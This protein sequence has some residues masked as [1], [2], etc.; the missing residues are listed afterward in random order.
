MSSRALPF[1]VPGPLP[2]PDFQFGA[3]TSAS[4]PHVSPDAESPGNVHTWAFPRNEAD[5]DTEDSYSSTCTSNF[6]IRMSGLNI[7]SSQRSPVFVCLPTQGTQEPGALPLLTLFHP[8]K[9][10]PW[11]RQRTLAL[12][13]YERARLRFG[14]ILA[15][16]Y[17]GPTEPAIATRKP[18]IPTIQG[19][20]H[21]HIQNNIDIAPHTN[22]RRNDVLVQRIPF[23]PESN[24]YSYT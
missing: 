18:S 19:V 14:T 10:A 23:R 24:Q 4:P 22:V 8:W 1:P 17:L 11:I 20:P 3:S 16:T 2:N 15:N 21:S 7:Q 13:V 5:Q 12:R 6:E 9:Y